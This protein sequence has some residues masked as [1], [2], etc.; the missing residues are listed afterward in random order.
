MADVVYHRFLIRCQKSI[1]RHDDVTIKPQR[2]QDQIDRQE[3]HQQP[4]IFCR[5]LPVYPSNMQRNLLSTDD[6]SSQ[7]SDIHRYAQAGPLTSH[8]NTSE[9]VHSTTNTLLPPFAKME[10]SSIQSKDQKPDDENHLTLPAPYNLPKRKTTSSVYNS[11]LGTPLLLPAPDLE[12]PLDAL[13]KSLISNSSQRQEGLS[14]QINN[15]NDDDDSLED[16][17]MNEMF[18]ENERKSTTCIKISLPSPPPYISLSS[19]PRSTCTNYPPTPTSSVSPPLSPPA[20]TISINS[21]N[22]FT[23]KRSSIHLLSKPAPWCANV[24]SEDRINRSHQQNK[25]MEM[26]DSC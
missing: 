3:N 17:V 15:N 2:R 13:H 22:S 4:P 11:S 8:S 24:I 10:T 12:N 16:N 18:N 21:I 5:P 26:N 7:R 9:V 25:L 1:P 23:S 20:K 6:F 19:S 14:P